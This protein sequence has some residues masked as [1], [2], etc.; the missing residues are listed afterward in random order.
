V[1]DVHYL[2]DMGC[3]KDQ[4]MGRRWS[5]VPWT[6]DMEDSC[7]LV[8]KFKARAPEERKRLVLKLKV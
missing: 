3:P 8:V 6:R 4:S 5:W 7:R 2:P 1:A